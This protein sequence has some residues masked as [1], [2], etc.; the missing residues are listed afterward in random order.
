MTD[1]KPDQ[2]LKRDLLGEIWLTQDSGHRLVRRC[3]DPARWWLRP[4]ARRLAA[5]EARAL[6][7][8]DEIVEIPGLEKWD[9]SELDREWLA[10]QPMQVARPRDRRYYRDALRLL[11]RMHRGGVVHND[12]AKEPNWLVLPDGS[13]A[14]I[15]FQVAMY[16]RRRGKIFRTLAREDVRHLLKHKRTYLP[17]AL[18]ARQRQVLAT[19]AL[20]ARLWRISGKQVYLWFTRGVLGWSDREGADDRRPGS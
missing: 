11:R 13:P 6:A 3:T 7:A 16:F 12:S 10:G 14:L 19:P 8:L 1:S 18:T 20:S 5:R 2:L 4:L 17:Q 15:D 9:G